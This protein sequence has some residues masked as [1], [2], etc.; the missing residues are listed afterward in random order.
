MRLTLC[1]ALAATLVA[2]PAVAQQR[3]AS[4]QARGVVLSPLSL[5]NV[6]PLD[7]GTVA[8][9]NALGTVTID[10][11]TGVR[12]VGGGVTAVPSTPSRAR[13]DGLGQAGQTVVLTLAP[14]T[15]NVIVDAANDSITVNSMTLDASNATTR[16]IGAGGNFSVY[17]GGAFG[18]AANQPN[19]VYSGTFTLTADYQ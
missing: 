14:P 1:A 10:A 12:T 6:A 3:T 4:G 9:S 2:T 8:T 7:F 18:L 5:Q 17:V 11:E 19:G 13:F 15:G 16:V